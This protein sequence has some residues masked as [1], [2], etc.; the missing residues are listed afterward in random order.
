MQTFRFAVNNGNTRR[1]DQTTKEVTTIVMI[2]CSKVHD[3]LQSDENPILLAKLASVHLNTHFTS[4]LA[5]YCVLKYA[6]FIVST[7]S[8]IQIQ[9][10]LYFLLVNSSHQSLQIHRW[11]LASCC[12]DTFS[13]SFKYT[14]TYHKNSTDPVSPCHHLRDI[15]PSG[16]E[17]R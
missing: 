16:D 4:A 8:I 9:T 10:N 5:D 6:A 12:V 15:Q 17:K 13:I 14:F 1:D 3:P 11:C 7:T 2:T